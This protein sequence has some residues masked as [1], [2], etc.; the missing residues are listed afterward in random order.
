MLNDLKELHEEG[1]AADEYLDSLA[2]RVGDLEDRVEEDRVFEE[3]LEAVGGKQ[4]PPSR[5]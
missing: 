2:N 4:V 3:V 5:N 1:K